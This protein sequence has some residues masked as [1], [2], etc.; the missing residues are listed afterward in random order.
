[1]SGAF[2][3]KVVWITGGGS[4]IGKA[5]ALE[6]ARQG[7]DLALSGRRVERLEEVCAEVEA[8]GRQ[9]IA[10]QCD[11]AR[12]LDVEVAVKKVIEHFGRMDVAVA[13]A[14]FGVSGKFEELS[15]AD[16]KRQ[17]DVNVI[18]LVSTARHA[19]PHLK[20]TQGRLGL[21][22]SVMGVLS[23]P[24]N[25]PYCASKAA[26]R[27]IGQVLSMELHGTGV[28]CTVIQPGFVES[29]IGRVDNKGNFRQDWS[30]KRPKQFM[31]SAKDA[32]RVIARAMHKRRREFTFTQHGRL[33]AL[34]GQHT[35][36]FVHLALTRFGK[37]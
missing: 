21:V 35:P 10:V 29:D 28:S 30:D 37:G 27:S 15:A 8:L 7:A 13:N 16:W 25:G 24:G 12:E 32:A 22:G 19:L 11:V 20:K 1:M 17:F 26:V 34:L 33:G 18:G 14:G 4:G 36:S 9:A 2:T 5:M 23:V 6:F 31:W 3:G